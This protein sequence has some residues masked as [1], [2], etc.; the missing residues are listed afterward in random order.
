MT[1]AIFKTRYAITKSCFS[2]FILHHPL[3]QGG[4][5]NHPTRSC[6]SCGEIRTLHAYS[7]QTILKILCTQQDKQP[8]NQQEAAPKA[9]KHGRKRSQNEATQRMQPRHFGAWRMILAHESKH[10]AFAILYKQSIKICVVESCH[11]SFQIC[12]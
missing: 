2:F 1:K 10:Y 9:P 11:Q 8:Q 4:F 12:L 5:A 7:T 3:S 6:N